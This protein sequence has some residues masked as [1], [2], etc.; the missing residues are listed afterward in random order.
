MD[1]CRELIVHGASTNQAEEVGK[2]IKNLVEIQKQM[3]GSEHSQAY[4]IWEGGK[5][6]RKFAQKDKLSWTVCFV[7]MNV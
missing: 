6:L 1:I 3:L 5:N 4:Q 7:A 2:N